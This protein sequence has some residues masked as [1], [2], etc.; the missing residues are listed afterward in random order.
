MTPT[1]AMPITFAIFETVLLILIY[2][3][4]SLVAELLGTQWQEQ[5]LAASTLGHELQNLQVTDLH[6]CL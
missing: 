5:D 1:D 3:S 4:R 2:Y 6:G